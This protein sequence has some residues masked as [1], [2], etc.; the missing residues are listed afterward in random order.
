MASESNT[1]R[2]LLSDTKRC[3]S[4][5]TGRERPATPEG[6]A[7]ER[8]K[9]A[10]NARWAKEPDRLAAT[11]P[12][13]DAAFQ[14]LLDEVDPERTLSEAERLKRVKNAQQ[15][16]LARIRLAASRVR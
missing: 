1:V 15:A 11:K 2:L 14:K 9:I 6:V 7:A 10:A 3:A 16:Q 13:R 12:G 8:A 4:G 5:S